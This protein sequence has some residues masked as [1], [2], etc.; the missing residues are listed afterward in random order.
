MRGKL[1]RVIEH[2]ASTGPEYAL[3]LRAYLDCYGRRRRRAAERISVHPNTFRYRI[4]RLVELF[5]I[6]LEERGRAP[7]ARAAVPAAGRRRP[8]TERALAARS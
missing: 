6:D 3:T 8:V 4:R 5:D 2:D 1:T 7:G